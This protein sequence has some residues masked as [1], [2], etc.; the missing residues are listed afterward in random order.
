ME[1]APT[2]GAQRATKKARSVRGTAC[3][4]AR[5]GVTVRPRRALEQGAVYDED[6]EQTIRRD[7][8]IRIRAR[9][10]EL[11]LSQE[12]LAHRLEIRQHEVSRWER[13]RVKPS[14]TNLQLL[15]DALECDWRLLVTPLEPEAA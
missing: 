5:S 14:G 13:G 4:M 15:G 6:V 1:S 2:D 10:T 11:G 9:R 7:I 8:G 12:D 3:S